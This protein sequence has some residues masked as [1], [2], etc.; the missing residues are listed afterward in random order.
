MVVLPPTRKMAMYILFSFDDLLFL[1]VL[2]P[3][4]LGLAKLAYGG[5]AE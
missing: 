5:S 2:L 1:T 4:F 3:V